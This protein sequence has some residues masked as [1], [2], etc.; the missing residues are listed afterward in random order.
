MTSPPGDRGLVG[1]RDYDRPVSVTQIPLDLV[2]F[3][4]DGVLVDSEPLSNAVLARALTRAGLSTTPE[5]A[6]ATYKGLH[7]RDVL[8]HAEQA[9]GGPL[10]SDFVPAFEDLRAEAFRRELKPVEGAAEAVATLRAAGITVCVASQG[11]RSKTELTLGLTGL[12]SLFAD[13]AVFSAHSVRRGKPHPDLFLHAART[14]GTP[15][16]RTAVVED[17]VVGVSAAVA[18]GMR[19]IGYGADSDPD[20][21]RGAGAEVIGNLAELP[22]HL[23]LAGFRHHEL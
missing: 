18:A 3:D 11:K 12:R 20:A 17:T 2:I 15:P 10:P 22:G 14:M 1:P 21:L 7:I 5:Q 13:D 4:C 23:G 6:V 19:V 8:E 9:L 16:E